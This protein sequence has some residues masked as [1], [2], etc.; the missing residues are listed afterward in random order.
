MEGLR[1]GTNP[2]QTSEGT[3]SLTMDVDDLKRKA[4]RF[5]ESLDRDNGMLDTLAPLIE[6]VPHLEALWKFP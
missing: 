6:K 3:A 5:Q 2:T 1:V 4:T